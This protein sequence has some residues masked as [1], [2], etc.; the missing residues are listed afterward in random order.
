MN[1]R[2]HRSGCNSLSYFC[3]PP[4][5]TQRLR[6][7]VSCLGSSERDIEF[8]ANSWSQRADFSVAEGVQG[9]IEVIYLE[10]RPAG[11]RRPF[12]AEERNLIDSL[13]E[14]LAAIERRQAQE[15]VILLQTIAMEVGA[16][17]DLPS[18]LEV[19]VRRVSEKTGWAID[20]PGSRATMGLSSIVPAWISVATGLEKF[21]K[22]L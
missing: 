9:T 22:Y 20:K 7:P 17:N 19:V 4:G 12:L 21:R 3:R 2:R 6:L 11:T 8:P 13:A 14:M 18:A 1:S 16:A 10:E 5:S 15:Q